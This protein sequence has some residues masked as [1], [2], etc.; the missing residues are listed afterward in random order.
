MNLA[1]DQNP[2]VRSHSNFRNLQAN[3]CLRVFKRHEQIAIAHNQLPTA[4]FPITNFFNTPP[5]QHRISSQTP[6][7]TYHH[8]S[9]FKFKHTA[10]AIIHHG[11]F[12][13]FDST[14]AIRKYICALQYGAYIEHVVENNN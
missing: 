7:Q 9:I 2:T 12:V 14:S 8:T 5:S 1:T 10:I 4:S 13:C 3:L 11:F 6:T